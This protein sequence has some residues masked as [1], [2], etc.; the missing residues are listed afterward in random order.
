MG[1]ASGPIKEMCARPDP[2]LYSP[3]QVLP[4]QL[5]A[6]REMF[7]RMR[8]LIPVLDRRAS[9]TGVDRIDSIKDLVPLL[10]SHATYK[11]YPQAF[12][13]SR[14]WDKLTRWLGLVSTETFEGVDVA[15]ATDIDDWLD[16]MWAAGYKVTTSSGTGGKV[17]LLPK[18]D[19]DLEIFHEYLRRFR[20]WPEPAV[21]ANDRHFFQFGPASGAYTGVIAAGFA[22]QDFARPDSVHL[23]VDEPL[24][25]AKVSQMAAFRE[26]LKDGTATP[27]DIATVEAEGAEQAAKSSARMNEMIDEII[28]LRHEPQ[29]IMGMSATIYE[30]VTRARAQGIP[31]GQFHPDTIASFGGGTKHFKLPEDYDAQ[32]RSFFGD[33]IYSSGYGMTEMSW[34]S[35]HCAGGNYHVPPTVLP[36]ILNEAGDELVEPHQ[37]VVVGRF[38]FVDLLTDIR[39]GGVISGDRVTVDLDGDCP[40]GRGGVNIRSIVR[41]ESSLGDDKIQ[42]SG[43][44]DAYIRGAVVD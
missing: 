13:A 44:I 27:A 3:S 38:G 26:K 11:S 5:E 37:G 28:R 22:V 32:I 43:T 21:A 9:D 14:Q 33:V 4:I 41:F 23:L 39:W 18:S 29:Y 1:K 25:I 24:R 35:T 20:G 10:L 6:S 8:P 40:C 36:L 15:G 17:S 16:R 42:C 30:V 12:V 34:L 31:D 19:L 2:Y 7:A